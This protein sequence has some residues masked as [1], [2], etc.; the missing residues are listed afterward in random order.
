MHCCDF[1]AEGE[2][3]LLRL[4]AAPGAV[5]IEV[6]PEGMFHTLGRT[7]GARD[8]H[9]STVSIAFTPDARSATRTSVC[10]ETDKGY[11][12]PRFDVYPD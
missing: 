7:R 12:K 5:T 2:A 4:L 9:P 8:Q 6:A 3:A 1:S 11:R 10:S